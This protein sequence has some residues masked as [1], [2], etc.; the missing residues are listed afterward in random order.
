M[1][2]AIRDRVSGWIASAIL[3]FVS[4]PFALWGIQ[5]YF[6]GGA[7][8]TAAKVNGSEI[9]VAAFN[10]ELQEQKRQLTQSLGGKLPA[11]LWDETAMKG[12]VVEGMIQREILEQTARDAGFHVSDAQLV[13]SIAAIPTFQ[14]GGKFDPTRYAQMLSAQR[15]SQAQFEEGL[16]QDLQLNQF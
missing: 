10:A 12:R 13:A 11:E 14:T 5:T 7:P 6:S 8:Q 15:R 9:P 1:L 4:I 3:V 16:R 2:T